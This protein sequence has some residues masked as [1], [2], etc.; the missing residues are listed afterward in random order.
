MPAALCSNFIWRSSLHQSVVIEHP[1]KDYSPQ[2]NS[3]QALWS[4]ATVR[5]AAES[6]HRSPPNH[7]ILLFFIVKSFYLI[8][9]L[10]V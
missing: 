3:H 7:S 2:R 8:F 1:W 9:L 6:S 5:D 10:L 4:D